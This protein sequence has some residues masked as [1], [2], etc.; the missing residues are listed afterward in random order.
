MRAGPGAPERLLTRRGAWRDVTG[1]GAPPRV[2]V[3]GAERPGH[4][5]AA[6]VGRQVRVDVRF[7]G[8]R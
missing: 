5:V 4:G 8:T 7:D 1:E 3:D 6:R 2:R